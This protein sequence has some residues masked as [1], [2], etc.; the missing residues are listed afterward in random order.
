MVDIQCDIKINV[1]RELVASY[2]VDPDNAPEWYVNI[3]SAK[4]LTPGPLKEGAK[5]AFRAKF[6]GKP[7][8]YTYEV[9]ELS[10]GFRL[11]MRTSEGPFPME[12]SYSWESLE[13]DVCRMT[14]CNRGRPVGFSRFVAPLMGL[15]MKK[16]MGKD[17]R[18][19]KRI[20]ERNL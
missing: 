5:I 18:T 8:E 1:S 11:V 9:V 6:M 19:L 13:E 17:L 16:A 3:E 4:R 15:M 7:L 2:A 12:T 20:L 14:L 10:E